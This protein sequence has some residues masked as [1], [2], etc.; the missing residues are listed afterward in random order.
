LV[1]LVLARGACSPSPTWAAG[2][3]RSGRVISDDSYLTSLSTYLDFTAGEQPTGGRVMH[4]D[5]DLTSLSTC[6]DFG[7]AEKPLNR[8]KTTAE[9]YTFTSPNQNF[10]RF[11]GSVIYQLGRNLGDLVGAQHSPHTRVGLTKLLPSN[12]NCRSE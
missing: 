3:T 11:R 1:W 10:P 5:F 7:A 6:L 12:P 4:S 8:S 9:Q 2:I